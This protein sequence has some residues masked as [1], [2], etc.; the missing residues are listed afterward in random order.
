MQLGPKAAK[1]ALLAVA[2]Q[3]QEGTELK[4]PAEGVNPPVA[5]TAEKVSAN[6]A[7]EPAEPVKGL[8]LDSA[9]EFKK[10]LRK[11]VETRPMTI[12]APVDLYDDLQVIQSV[13]RMTMTEVL[14][15]AAR[16]LVAELM[17]E[18]DAKLKGAR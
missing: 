15:N 2:A 11:R 9:E 8:T 12:R 4:I 7:P 17:A 1:D 16:P 14:V 13:L 10:L 3:E 18:V 5:G 6:P